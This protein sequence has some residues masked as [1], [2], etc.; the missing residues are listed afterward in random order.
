MRD[1]RGGGMQALT[2]FA[3]YV[4][5]GVLVACL[6][7]AGAPCAAQEVDAPTASDPRSGGSSVVAPSP[8]VVMT[9]PVTERVALKLYGFYV[10]D[11]SAPVAQ[12]DVPIRTVKFL[13]ITP[14]YLY[15]WIPPSGLNK[16]SPQSREFSDSYEE[17]QFRIDGTIAFPI[18]NFEISARNMYVRRF[19]PAPID[20]INRYRGRISVAHPLAIQGRIW[21]PF[22]SYESF[23]E[24]NGGWNR[25][26]VWTGVTVPLAKQ[27][28]FQP[29]YMWETSHGNK[30]IHY[31]LFGV[32]VSTK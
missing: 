1:A 23:Y 25:D 3:R 8:F 28:S 30:D 24:R 10:G 7:S 2:R 14:S 22:A 5:P 15:N 6:F 16:M 17:Q 11:V 21:K 29:S 26:R 12:V 4:V 19:R 32:Y 13:T 18:H 20:D 27:V 31:L 9:A